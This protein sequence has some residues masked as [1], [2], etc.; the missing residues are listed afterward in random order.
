MERRKGKTLE[1]LQNNF[2]KQINTKCSV[3]FSLSVGNQPS[4][5]LSSDG[6]NCFFSSSATVGNKSIPID[7]ME[8]ST[9]TG[10]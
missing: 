7:F 10:K 1:V 6:M 5:N 2:H 9:E 4:E 3:F 8:D